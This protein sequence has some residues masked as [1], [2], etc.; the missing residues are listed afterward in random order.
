MQEFR[1]NFAVIIGVNAYM[2]GIPALQNAVNDASRCARILSDDHGYEVQ[3]LLDDQVTLEYLKYLLTELLP[4]QVQA[5]DRL[6]LYFAGHGIA[7]DGDDGPAGYLIPQNA[8]LGNSDTFLPMIALH[9]ALTALPCRHMLLILDCCFAGAFRWA[10]V[11]DLLLAPGVMYQE[12]YDRFI[13]DPA[14]QVITSAAHDQRAFDVFGNRGGDQHSPFAQILFEALQGQADVSPAATGD[15]PAGDGVITATE[16]Y[17]YLREHVE[18]TTL[19]DRQRQTPGLWPLQKHDK[20]EYIFLTPGRELRLPPAPPLNYENN[21]YRGLQ[22]FE[23]EHHDLFFGRTRLIEDLQTFVSKHQLTVVLGASGTGKSSLVKAGLLPRLHHSSA[24]HWHI[25]GPIRP[26]TSETSPMHMLANLLSEG[27]EVPSFAERVGVWKQANAE[28]MLLLVID[29]L[30]ELVTLNRNEQQRTL[31]LDALTEALVAHPDCLRVVTTLRADF[32]PQFASSAL[33]PFWSGA[34]FVISPMTQDELREV[35]EGPATLRVLYFEPGRLVERLINEV[36]QTPGALSLLSFTLSELYIKYLEHRGDSRA[37]TEEDYDQLGGVAGSLRTRIGE[38]YA[39]LTPDQQATMQRLMLRMVSLEGGELTRRRV[40]RSELTYPDSEENERVDA[41]INRLT[42]VRLLVRGQTEEGHAYIEPAHDAL[43]RGW[44]QLWSWVQEATELLPLQRRLTQA[45]NDWERAGRGKK[46]LW[47]NDPRLTQVEQVRTSAESWLNNMETDFVAQSSIQRRQ[48]VRRLIGWVSAAF[49]VITVALI[50]AVWQRNIAVA[51]EESAVANQ[52]IAEER[53]R[54]ARARELAAVA[55]DNIAV[56]PERSILLAMRAVSETYTVDKTVTNEAEDALHRAIQASRVQQTLIGHRYKMN[57]VAFSPDDKH[58]ATADWN[59]VIKLWDTTTGEEILTLSDDYSPFFIEARSIF[60]MTFS[61]DGTLLAAA[62]QNKEATVWDVETGEEVFTLA[63]HDDFVSGVAFSPDGTRL[64]TSSGDGTVK[65]WDMSNGE[66]ISPT[67]TITDSVFVE[68][69]DASSIRDI[70]YSSDGQYL[71]TAHS[72]GTAKVWDATSGQEQVTLSGHTDPV[73]S[74]AFSPD[75]AYLATASRDG[76]TRIWDLQSDETVLELV[77]PKPVFSIGGGPDA[78]SITRYSS[79]VFDAEFNDDGTLLATAHID[80]TT[81]IWDT[82]TGEE[83]LSFGEE[84]LSLAGH[85]ARVN[86]VAFSADGTWL[87]TASWDGTA[88]LWNTATGRE[89]LNL[90]GQLS[91]ILDTSFSPDGTLLV[92]AGSDEIARVW[93]AATGEE[94]LTFT[95]HNGQIV[96]VAF[97]P[98]GQYLASTGSDNRVHL[99]N[100]T[101]GEILVTIDAAGVRAVSFSP[102]GNLIATAS[103]DGSAII[104]DA[105]CGAEERTLIEGSTEGSTIGISGRGQN[106][107]PVSTFTNSITGIAFSSDGSQIVTS[108][109]T[110]LQVWDVETGQEVNSFTGH[111]ADIAGVSFSPDGRMIASAGRDTTARLWDTETGD[112][113]R[114]LSEHSNSLADVVFDQSGTRLATASQDHSARVWDVASGEELMTILGHTDRVNAVSFSPDGTRLATA[115]LDGTA[116]IWNIAPTAEVFTLLNINNDKIIDVAY[117]PDGQFIAT[118]NESAGAKIWD[119]ATGAERRILE[120]HESSVSGVAFSPDGSR[121][122]TASLDQTAKVWNLENGEESLTLSGHTD[123]IAGITFSPDGLLLAT[124]SDDETA[125]VWDLAGTNLFVARHDGIVR[126][127]AFSADG[128]Y[129]VTSSDDRIAKVWDVASGEEVFR[130][131]EHNSI[132]YSAAFS[133]DPDGKLL[134]TGSADNTARIWS[135]EDGTELQ[136]LRGHIGA[137]YSV[138]FSPDGEQLATASLDNTVKVWDTE[139]GEEL[140]TLTGHTDRVL[141]V[142]FSPDG[143]RLATASLDGTSRIYL[144]D[145]EELMDLAQTRVTRTLRIDECQRFLQESDCE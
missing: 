91:D 74:V 36:V 78:V 64:A 125:R 25:L 22:S 119:A 30:E 81:K 137:I 37:L 127:V 15:L 139:S 47:N 141:A 109:G 35:I 133:P 138:A 59:G 143:T 68:R 126:D 106:G 132:V 50:V 108:S 130:I 39:R 65:L 94:Q 104:W 88:K 38:E 42:E 98:D 105:R 40:L 12:R 73:R 136:I 34:R 46:Y 43:V 7:L 83:V 123:R 142:A 33:K 77:G 70:E 117:S 54:V 121:L 79:T 93:D 26:G 14:W 44:D 95:E 116:R 102:D 13:R 100:V 72:D 144:L 129:L 45:A 57:L 101:T 85:T 92:T 5:E 23:E 6:L 66:I 99:W 84:V 11:R 20:G 21:P 56:D 27:Q 111:T 113:M 76:T 8:S 61:P 114:E 60:G 49:A 10:T 17:L 55:N 29:Q 52:A 124:A 118:A 103:Q 9:E 75:D 110:T 48:E 51:N 31:F 32:E 140:L 145:F 112:E 122:A 80:G 4:R 1:R 90:P 2:N 63:G 69:A 24:E 16:L 19:S 67:E 86:D 134:A 96:S 128:T 131:T 97:H 107:L 28:A 62:S 41:L 3:L 71:A 89:K 120:G 58:L 135:V 82:T 53:A 115:S 18:V 87:A